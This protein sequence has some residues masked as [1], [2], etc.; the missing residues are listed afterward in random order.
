MPAIVTLSGA[1][2]PPAKPVRIS[3]RIRNHA[4]LRLRRMRFARG[5]FGC[6]FRMTIAGATTAGSSSFVGMTVG[7]TS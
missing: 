3:G 2:G 1:K 4:E 5:F 6:A 7:G